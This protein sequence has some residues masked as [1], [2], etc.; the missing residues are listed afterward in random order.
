MRRSR[1]A[2]M[3]I[4]EV[5]SRLASCDGC[6]FLRKNEDNR[7]TCNRPDEIPPCARAARKR[8]FVRYVIYKKGRE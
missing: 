7:N 2:N 1:M 6:M 4:L 5:A 3:K 8:G